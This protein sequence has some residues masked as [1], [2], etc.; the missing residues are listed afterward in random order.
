MGIPAHVLAA[1]PADEPEEPSIMFHGFLV[2]PPNQISSK[3][4]DPV[5]SLAMRTAPVFFNLRPNSTPSTY[6]SAN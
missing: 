4:K 5:A 2:W 1:G 6:A 3:A